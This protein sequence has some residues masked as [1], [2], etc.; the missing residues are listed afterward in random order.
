M[1]YSLNFILQLFNWYFHFISC[2]W[3]EFLRTHLKW[4]EFFF[5]YYP[6]FVSCLHYP[7]PLRLWII[8]LCSSFGLLLAWSLFSPNSSLFC[9]SFGSLYSI[10]EWL[11]Y[12]RGFPLTLISGKPRYLFM[13]KNELLRGLFEALIV[14]CVVNFQIP[15]RRM[16]QCLW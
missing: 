10:L 12:L 8:A 16:L 13:I 11:L 4:W 14:W 5:I 2:L 15:K 3:F 7:I 1:V 9:L 6:L